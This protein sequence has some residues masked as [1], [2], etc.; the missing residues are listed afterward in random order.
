LTAS[1]SAFAGSIGAANKPSIAAKSAQ[2]AFRV[3][4]SLREAGVRHGFGQSLLVIEVS[5]ACA[6]RAHKLSHWPERGGDAGAEEDALHV[7][8]AEWRVRRLHRRRP[9]APMLCRATCSAVR[10]TDTRRAR[11]APSQ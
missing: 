5:S 4:R 11:S 8:P 7:C 9:F 3:P 2:G 10:A 1:G 6:G